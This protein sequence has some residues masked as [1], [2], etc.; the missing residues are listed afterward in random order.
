MNPALSR[1]RGFTLIELMIVL[2]VMAIL[3]AI[4]YPSFVNIMIRNDRGDARE[5]LAALQLA[6]ERH[7]ARESEY[8]N[9]HT[10]LTLPGAPGQS[11]KGLYN[12]LVTEADRGGFTATATARPGTR[13]TRDSTCQTLTLIVTTTGSQRLP[14]EC[15]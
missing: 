9:T 13:Q 11:P 3:V 2:V 15:W 4:A 1:S 8:A 14:E 7:R 6:Q 10:A 12:I 5:A